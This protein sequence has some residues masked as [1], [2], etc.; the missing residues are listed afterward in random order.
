LTAAEAAKILPAVN[1]TY[2]KVIYFKSMNDEFPLGQPYILNVQG[3]PE[4]E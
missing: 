3:M 1:E 4:V 2:G